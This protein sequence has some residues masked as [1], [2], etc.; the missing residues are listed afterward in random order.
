M[1]RPVLS[2]HTISLLVNAYFDT[3]NP[4]FPIVSRGDFAAKSSPSPLLLY[5]ICGLG[6]TRRQF[7][8]EI[9]AG[10]RGVING[11]LR[12]NDILSD[13]RFENV[14]A[15]VSFVSPNLADK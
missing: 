2:G 11:L 12:S 5:A 8:R 14:Q 1:N 6:S 10:V 7:P 9:F 13:A 3:I 15:L 4:L